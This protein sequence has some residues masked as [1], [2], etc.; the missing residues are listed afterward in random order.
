MESLPDPLNDRVIKQI[1]PPPQKPLSS[2]LFFSET[3]KGN[4]FYYFSIFFNREAKLEG[5]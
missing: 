5:D 4:Q 3:N 1:K 2:N